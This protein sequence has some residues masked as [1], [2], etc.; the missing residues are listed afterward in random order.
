MFRGTL[1]RF[2]GLHARIFVVQGKTDLKF[3]HLGGESCGASV[4]CLRGCC[5]SLECWRVRTRTDKAE[6]LARSAAWS[7]IPAADPSAARMC[8]LSKRERNR[9]C[10][11]FRRAA[12][13]FS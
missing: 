7:L 10:A 5:Y 12:R 2:E 3:H 4:D 11:S 1:A 8:K 9:S 6:R 13:E